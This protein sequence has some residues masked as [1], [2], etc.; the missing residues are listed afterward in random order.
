MYLNTGVGE[1]SGKLHIPDIGTP[2]ISLI[3]RYSDFANNT[4]HMTKSNVP[5]FVASQHNL[6]RETNNL[7]N[8]NTVITA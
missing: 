8:A 6:Q 2:K 4:I 5:N 7:Y 3:F 1:A